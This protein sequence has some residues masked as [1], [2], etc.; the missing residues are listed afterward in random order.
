MIEDI[1]PG[2]TRL[3]M[4]QPIKVGSPIALRWLRRDFSG[5]IRYCYV[6]GTDYV[7][8]FQ[9]DPDQDDWPLATRLHR[10]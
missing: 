2:G 3:R 9:K 1:S 5:T 10:K 8:G 7:L 4:A 6:S